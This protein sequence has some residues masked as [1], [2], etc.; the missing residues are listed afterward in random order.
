MKLRTLGRECEVEADPMRS[1]AVIA[2]LVQ[3]QLSVRRAS[4]S[5]GHELKLANGS[6]LG[7]LRTLA[8][9][10]VLARG[11]TPPKIE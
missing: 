11:P 9:H 8:G 10:F 3:P 4:G 6:P 5:R 1:F 2:G 7:S